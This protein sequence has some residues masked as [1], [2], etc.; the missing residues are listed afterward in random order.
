MANRHQKLVGR[1]H[2]EHDMGGMNSNFVEFRSLLVTSFSEE[3]GM[4]LFHRV[5]ETGCFIHHL[6]VQRPIKDPKPHLG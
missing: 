4:I 6:K 1:L 5:R 2:L 3:R